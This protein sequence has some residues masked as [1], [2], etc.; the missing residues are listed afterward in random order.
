MFASSNNRG[1]TLIEVMIAMIILMVGMMALLNTAAVV[2]QNNLANVLRDEALSVAEEL[3]IYYKNL[4][5]DSLPSSSIPDITAT[6]QVKGITTN[7]TVSTSITSPGTDTR[8]VQITVSWTYRS[9]LFKH[10]LT[11]IINR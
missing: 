8:K 4:P 6:R 7:Y 2:I 11:S 9:T 3:M 1:F 5:F 10:R